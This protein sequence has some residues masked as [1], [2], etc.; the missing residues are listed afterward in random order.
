[1]GVGIFLYAILLPVFMKMKLFVVL[2]ISAV[3]VSSF[4]A[5]VLP[6]A[7]ALTQ[8]TDF[9]NRHTTASWGNSRICGDHICKSGEYTEMQM[10]LSASQRGQVSSNPA[11]HAKGMMPT[12][13]GSMK[14]SE[15]MSMNA[16]MTSMGNM[17]TPNNK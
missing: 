5:T 17:T 3:L 7:S 6:S 15:K 16:N 8:R 1:M 11:S 12:T 10:K 13:T 4:A 9:S 14:M 2:V